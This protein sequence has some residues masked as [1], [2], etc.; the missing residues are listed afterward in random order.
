M[1]CH[2]CGQSVVPKSEDEQTELR[3][4]S[5]CGETF[6]DK[7]PDVNQHMEICPK[8]KKGPTHPLAH[9]GKSVFDEIL[10]L[11]RGK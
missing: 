9:N 11:I 5:H 7:C 3:F 2:H 10:D 1:K 6:C 4:C 8:C